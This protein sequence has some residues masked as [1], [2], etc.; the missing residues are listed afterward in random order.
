MNNN[1]R[2]QPSFS[3][4]AFKYWYAKQPDVINNVLKPEIGNINDQKVESRLGTERLTL[5]ITIANSNLEPKQIKE[6]AK[7]FSSVGGI[8]K[9][10]HEDHV[11][12]ECNNNVFNLPKRFVKVN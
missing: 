3:I 2:N 11:V 8:V 4:Y 5:E 10:S 7:A 1:E 12:I 9:E 6:L